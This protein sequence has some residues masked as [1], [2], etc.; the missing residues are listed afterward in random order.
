MPEYERTCLICGTEFLG[1]Q[2]VSRYCSTPCRAEAENLRALLDGRANLARHPW[3]SLAHRLAA[4]T[5]APDTALARMLRNAASEAERR[6]RSVRRARPKCT[7]TSRCCRTAGARHVAFLRPRG[8]ATSLEP[9]RGPP[10]LQRL[11]AAWT[12]RRE[13]ET[14]SRDQRQAATVAACRATTEATPSERERKIPKR[15][16]AALWAATRAALR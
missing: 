12:P 16:S 10:D 5:G 6:E 2:S 4:V 8:T 13:I 9:A 15:R 11:R 7:G 3:P 14:Q 1:R